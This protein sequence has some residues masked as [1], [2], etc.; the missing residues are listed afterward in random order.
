MTRELSPFGSD[1]HFNG[2]KG[3]QFE[4]P[5]VGCAKCQATRTIQPQKI[6]KI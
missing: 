4:T 2:K 3:K 6:F 5:Q 1:L